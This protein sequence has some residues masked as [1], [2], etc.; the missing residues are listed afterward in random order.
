MM[1]LVIIALAL[2]LLV[3]GFEMLLVLGLPALAYKEAFYARLPDPAVVQ[4]IVGGIDHTTLLAIPFFIFAANLMGSGQIARQLIGVVTALVGHTRGGIGHVVVGGSMAFGSVSG[5]APATV[6]AMGRMAYPEMRR[7]GYSEKFSLGLLVASAET[8]LLIPPSITLIIYGWITGTSISQLFAAG[9]GVGIVLGLAFAVFVELQARRD[10]VSHGDRVPWSGRLRA[11][12]DAK[13]ALGMPVIILGGIY[14]GTITPTEAAAVSVVYAIAVEMLVFRSLNLSAL[15]RITEDSAINTAIIF[16]LLAMGG[17]I[18]FFVTLA[19]VPDMIL[20]LL[21]SADAG[22]IAFLIAVNLCFFIAGMFVDPNS[23]L[24]VLVPPLYPVALSFGIDPVHFGMVV[25]LNVCLG[26]ITPPFG[27]DIF[28]AS[29]TLGKPVTD[30]I[31]GV[32]PFVVVNVIVL[33]LITYVPQI[34]LLVPRLI[35]G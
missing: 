7:A 11:V 32:W 4:K 1:F 16:V 13:W 29:S 24:L 28:V 8:A 21:A 6:A 5:S 31:R 34:S 12:W 30:I 23:T 2:V 9:L 3:T 19:Q 35:Y 25:T 20:G 27:L 14:S 26:M 15:I 22:K 33:L 17:L 10:K 18:S